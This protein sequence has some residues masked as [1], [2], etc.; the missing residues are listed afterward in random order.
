MLCCGTS[1][2]ISLTVF[3]YHRCYFCRLY[4]CYTFK[5]HTGFRT[6]YLFCSLTNC[7]V[8]CHNNCRCYVKPVSQSS[9][10]VGLARL[11]IYAWSVNTNASLAVNVQA[12]AVMAVPFTQTALGGRVLRGYLLTVSPHIEYIPCCFPLLGLR[13]GE[14]ISYLLYTIGSVDGQVL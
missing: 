11:W 10:S 12:Q 4:I 9:A 7:I 3:C 1:I 6:L 14:S 2:R 13:S 5:V 8:V